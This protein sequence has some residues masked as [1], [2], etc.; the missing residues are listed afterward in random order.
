MKHLS[1]SERE[2]IDLDSEEYQRI[3]HERTE[4]RFHF[5]LLVAVTW[6]PLMVV[7]LFIGGC[8]LEG[9][10]ASKGLERKQGKWREVDAS[11]RGP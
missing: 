5:S 4:R 10:F 1:H 11:K 6:I 2:M 9:F 3:K 8:G 7:A